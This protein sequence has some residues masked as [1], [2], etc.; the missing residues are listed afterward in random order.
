MILGG[1]EVIGLKKNRPNITRYC[2]DL[3]WNVPGLY[4]YPPTPALLRV[5]EE[6][7][8]PELAETIDELHEV[9][10]YCIAASQNTSILHIQLFYADI[11]QQITHF[12]PCMII[13][14]SYYIRSIN[15]M[16]AMLFTLYCPRCISGV[17]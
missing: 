4:L 7:R 5:K 16:I 12:S 15:V 14:Y 8:V 11:L 1:S 17:R 9:D 3:C 6:Q 2:G 13:M 10:I